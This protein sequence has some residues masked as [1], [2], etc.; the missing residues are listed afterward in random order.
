MKTLARVLVGLGAAA[1]PPD[2]EVQW[3]GGQV[4]RWTDVPVRRWTTLREGEGPGSTS[5]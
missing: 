5:P 3:V 1:D 4:E 2:V